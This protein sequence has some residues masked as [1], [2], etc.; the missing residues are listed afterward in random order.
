MGPH[1][2]GVRNSEGNIKA[3]RG[4]QEFR[5]ITEVPLSKLRGS[6]PLIFEHPGDRDFTRVQPHLRPRPKGAVNA[7]PIRIATRQERRARR[8]TDRLSDVKICQPDPG[9]SQCI[10]VGGLQSCRPLASQISITLIIRKNN[11]HIRLF[12]RP[13]ERAGGCGRCNANRNHD[14]REG[15]F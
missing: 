4:R 9:G 3:V 6:I 12:T 2:A 11:H 10:N 8:R 14:P 13:F 15:I 5:A 7:D 1:V